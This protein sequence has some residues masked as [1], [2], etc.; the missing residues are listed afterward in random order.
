M[1]SPEPPYRHFCCSP[2]T[3]GAVSVEAKGDPTAP[4]L[5]HSS[6][7]SVPMAVPDSGCVGARGGCRDLGLPL[8]GVGG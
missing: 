4:G 6:S 1:A 3:C 7:A 8:A 5:S 2:D